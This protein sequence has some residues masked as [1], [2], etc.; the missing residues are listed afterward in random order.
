[1]MI[2]KDLKII[3]YNIIP[4]SVKSKKVITDRIY[5]SFCEII[6]PDEIYDIG[7]SHNFVI[8]LKLNIGIGN[9]IKPRY[10]ILNWKKLLVDNIDSILIYMKN[11]HFEFLIPLAAIT[12][13]NNF[14]S[15]LKFN[16]DEKH[17]V[18]ILTMWKNC[19]QNYTIDELILPNLVN[20]QLNIY[21]KPNMKKNVLKR[22]LNE[23]RKMGCIERRE[24]GKL[25][26]REKEKL[27]LKY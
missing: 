21:E 22:I 14:Y 23:L 6:F 20:N 27:V 8:N 17:S 16:I 19:D 11:K 3:I 4:P 5:N 12:I 13:W 24:T 25:W 9:N 7:D 1:M 26:L 15:N 2:E 10:I 18:V